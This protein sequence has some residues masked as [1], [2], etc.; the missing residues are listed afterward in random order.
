MANKRLV[1]L[2]DLAIPSTGSVS[3]FVDSSQSYQGTVDRLATTIVDSYGLLTTDLNA[4]LMTTA[5]AEIILAGLNNATAATLSADRVDLSDL[6]FDIDG[7]TMYDTYVNT[8][9][10][11]GGNF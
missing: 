7:G 11:D 2:P 1:Q 8:S 4:G 5:N 6:F 9:T 10:F 3:Y